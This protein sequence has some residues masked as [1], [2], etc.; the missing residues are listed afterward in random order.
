MKSLGTVLI[1]VLCVLASGCAALVLAGAAGAGA[2]GGVLYAK[3]DLE[4]SLEHP[5]K[6]V[7]NA[8]R[9]GIDDVGLHLIQENDLGTATVFDCRR[10]DDKKVVVRV[11][12]VTSD[13]TKINIRV[14]TFG[15]EDY[16]RYLYDKIQKRL[17]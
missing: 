4:A 14:G 7:V 10:S 9:D 12:S 5:Y 17:D 13:L 2:A 6:D 8:S 3:G 15:D 16:S 11:T 1:G